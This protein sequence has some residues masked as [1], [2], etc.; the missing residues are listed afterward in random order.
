MN[1]LKNCVLFS[2]RSPSK[3]KGD[4]ITNHE[5]VKNQS[6]DFLRRDQSFV[7]PIVLD[8]WL[9]TGRYTHKCLVRRYNSQRVGRLTQ[10]VCPSPQFSKS[11]PARLYNIQRCSHPTGGPAPCT[12]VV[13]GH[14]GFSQISQFRSWAKLSTCP[15]APTLTL[16]LIEL[17]TF[18]EIYFKHQ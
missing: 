7:C 10:K 6:D 2:V 1:K 3:F 16:T 15:S 11:S 18:Q 12:S 5:R 14:V 4:D 13:A 17:Q 9:S 8:V